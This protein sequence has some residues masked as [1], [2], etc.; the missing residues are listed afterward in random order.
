MK[1]ALHVTVGIVPSFENE[2]I[3]IID[4]DSLN[5]F[6][7]RI[8]NITKPFKL[9]TLFMNNEL[10]NIDLLQKSDIVKFELFGFD[11]QNIYLLFNFIE[12]IGQNL[13]HLA[14]HQ[15]SDSSNNIEISLIVLQNLG[16]I[17]P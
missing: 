5:S 8:L 13:N 7:Q 4:Y 15:I 11:D 1:G 14:I 17:L 12:N 16:Q 6:I 9:K 2:S 3:H 10:L